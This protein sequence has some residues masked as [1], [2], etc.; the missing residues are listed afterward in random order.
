MPD[1]T[2]ACGAAADVAAMYGIRS[3]NAL[4]FRRPTTVAGSAPLTSSSRLAPENSHD[5][6]APAAVAAST[7]T[8]LPVRTS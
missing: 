5:T 2:P 7:S 1:V 4:L 8:N 3:D 6:A